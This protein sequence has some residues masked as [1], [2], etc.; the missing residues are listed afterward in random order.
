MNCHECRDELAAY[1]EGLV[2]KAGR[3]QIE[4]HLA[5]CPTCRTELT[6]VQ[7]LT[8]R[9][10]RDGLAAAPVSLEAAV[11]DRIFHQQA[12]ELRRLRM[13]RRIRLFGISGA[14]A[15]AAA[16]LVAVGLWHTPPAVA[17]KTVD[18]L[19]LGAAAV[20][21]GATVHIVAKMRTAP[22]DNFSYVNADLDFVRIDVWK[23]SGDK[24]KW[25]VEKPGRV[26]V[27]DG[28]STALLIRPDYAMKFPGPSRAAFDTGE[29]L[30]LANVHEMIANELQSALA[31]GGELKIDHETTAAGEKRLLVTVKTKSGLPA[32]DYLK[33]KFLGTSDMRRV[34][35]FDA[36]SGRL[37]GMDGYLHRSAGD[38][39]VLKVEYIEYDQHADPAIFTLKLPEGVQWAKEPEPLPDNEKYEKMTAKEAAQTFF[40][41]CEKADWDVAQVFMGR[42]LSQSLKEG[43]GGLEI[44]QLG[45]PFQSVISLL[46]GD[47]FVPYEIKLKD[48]TTRKWNLALRKNDTA[49]R[50]I[51]DGGI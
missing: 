23:Q 47:W 25:R 41:A 40:E 34:Y 1:L 2:D 4:S 12:L 8:A 46:N 13:R 31:R 33:N 20:P 30:E 11:M 29:L 9:L 35:H 16:I 50:F 6:E 48:G 42:R 38:V 18:V 26:A 28:E 49:R 14:M 27:M 7:Q 37:E 19:A 10:T 22:H 15:T 36:Q 32:L 17:E 43:L 51:I 44:V 24:P 21:E 45:E 39:L 5:G 3:S